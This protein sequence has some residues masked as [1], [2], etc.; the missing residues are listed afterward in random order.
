[1]DL[2]EVY[3][4]LNRE[5]F[6]E[7][8][9]TVSMGSLKTY[10]VFES[11]KIHARLHKL[12]RERLRKAAPQ[13]WQRIETGDQDLAREFSQGVLVSNLP[14]VAEILDALEIP[15]DGN[16]F[17]EKNTGAA[18]QL[19]D[20]WQQRIYD[21]FREQYAEPLLLLYINHLDWELGKPSQPFIP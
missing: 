1:M 20:G 16:G 9:K 21:K 18:E 15:H 6:E 2:P 19:K 11:F 17:F 3:R 8:I 7:L 4:A 5:R 12:N 10:Q 13:L 14:M